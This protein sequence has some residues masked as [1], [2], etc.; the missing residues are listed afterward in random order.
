MAGR[1]RHVLITGGSRGIG[2][3]IAQLFA[4]TGYRCTLISR[5]EENLKAAV[6]TL[7]SLL[8]TQV[9]DAS[10]NQSKPSPPKHSYIPGD[11]SLLSEFWNPDSS[12]PSSFSAYLPRPSV[13]DSQHSSKIDVLI[14]CAGV[15]QAKLFSRTDVCILTTVMGSVF[16]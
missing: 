13:Q 9:L 6:S 8:S 2:L 15:T 14:N 7:P 1:S 16:S 10:I 5:S 4:K 12:L 3:S 11:I